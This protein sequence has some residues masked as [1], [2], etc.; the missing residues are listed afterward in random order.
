MIFSGGLGGI[1]CLVKEAVCKLGLRGQSLTAVGH[2]P[3]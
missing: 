1:K 3:C 2:E